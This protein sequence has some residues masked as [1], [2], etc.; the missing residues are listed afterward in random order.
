MKQKNVTG[1]RI[2]GI[3]LILVGVFLAATWP[4]TE[5]CFGDI[6]FSAFRLPTWSG[7]STGVHYPAVLGAV[8]ILVGIIVV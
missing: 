7:G 4:N 1:K 6:L 5:I 2:A 3:T 8:L